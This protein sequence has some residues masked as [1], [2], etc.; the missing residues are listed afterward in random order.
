MWRIWHTVG[1]GVL[2]LG[3]GL[4]GLFIDPS[5][6][7]WIWILTMLLLTGLILVS[8]QGIV[9]RWLGFLIDD[10]NKMSLSRLQ[11]MLWT[12]IVLS[13]YWAGVAVNFQMKAAELEKY[14]ELDPAAIAIPEAIHRAS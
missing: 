11:F 9:G 4:A 8:G 14:K 13:G 5:E 1:L 10:R 2:V 6:R 7:V 3:I 12:V